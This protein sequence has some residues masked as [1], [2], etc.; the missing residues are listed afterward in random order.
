MAYMTSWNSA[1][2]RGGR[3]TGPV[4]GGVQTLLVTPR[5]LRFLRPHVFVTVTG[6]DD[7]EAWVPG[8]RTVA[9][10]RAVHAALVARYK[11]HVWGRQ[12]EG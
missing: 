7:V 11:R 12:G 6:L 8:A 10:A 5:W 1:I 2:R 3:E 9:Q 4:V